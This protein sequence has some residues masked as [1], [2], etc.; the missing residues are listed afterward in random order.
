MDTVGTLEPR[1]TLVVRVNPARPDPSD[2]RGPAECLRRGG[3]VV[4]PTETVYGL[5]AD[6]TNGRA[7]RAVFAAKGRPPDNPLIVHVASPGDVRPLVRGVSPGA[8]G[9]MRTFW[10]GPLSL[11]FPSSDR[12]APE[13]TSGLDTVAIRMPRHPVALELIRLAGVPVAAPSANLSGRPSPT[14]AEDALADLEGKVDYVLDAGPCPVGV[15]STVLDLT[16]PVPVVLRP[17]G[18]TLEELARVVGE[19]RLASAHDTSSGPA[20]S[21]GLRHRHYAPRA[22]LVV[23]LPGSA[24][25]RAVAEAVARAAA[26]ELRA[27][28]RVGVACTRETAAFLAQLSPEQ[29]PDRPLEQSGARGAR[30]SGESPVVVPWGSRGRAGEV[31]ANLFAVLR[32]LDRSRVDTIVA[33]GVPPEGLGLAVNDRLVRAAAAVLDLG[34]GSGARGSTALAEPEAPPGPPPP[35]LATPDL[36]LVVCTGNTCRSPLGAAILADRLRRRGAGVAYAVES[37][38]TAAV[39]GLPASPEAVEVARERGLDLT[40]H[41]SRPVT[42]DLLARARLILTMTREHKETLVRLHPGVA[43]RTFTF[44]GYAGTAGTGD[45]DSSGGDDAEDIRDPIG[46]GLEAYRRTADD[47]ESV[48]DRV[49]ERLLRPADLGDLLREE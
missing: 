3:L 45:R 49:V 40:A 33:E 17:G 18:V 22:K 26:Q 46:C 41:R 12:V 30:F 29:P 28:R 7:V 14:R 24:D 6:A 11:V 27:G 39:S 35:P 13:V 48:V 5:G 8:E 10:P 37:A 43:D 16:G 25:P 15:E 19:V 21:P 20:R 38:G 36:I 4:F 44:K 31:A 2:L 23:V 42:P 9:L 34:A 47:I 1:Q 32:D